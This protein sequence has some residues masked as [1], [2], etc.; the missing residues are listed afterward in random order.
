M[1]Q[2]FLKNE[3]DSMAQFISDIFAQL[4]K[5]WALLSDGTKEKHDTVTV[6]WGGML[7]N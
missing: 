3:G 5:K 4:D 2:C 6:S 7:Y 1:N